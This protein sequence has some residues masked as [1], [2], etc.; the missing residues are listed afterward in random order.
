VFS[1]FGFSE[2]A[3]LRIHIPSGVGEAGLEIV[4]GEF[5]TTRDLRVVC[6]A[7][8]AGFVLLSEEP[9]FAGATWVSFADTLDY[10]LEDVLGPR[11]L[12]AAYSNPFVAEPAVAS[13]PVVLVAPPA[14][15]RR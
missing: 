10:Q 4:G 5:T 3:Q 7:D 13:A 9:D 2:T 14:S 8:S 12:Y 6:T 11:Y 1:D 15:P